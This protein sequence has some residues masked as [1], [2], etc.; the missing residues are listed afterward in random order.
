MNDFEPGFYFT[1]GK[2]KYADTPLWDKEI[3]EVLS[4]IN[5]THR[6]VVDLGRPERYE[7]VAEFAIF[8]EE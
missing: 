1:R 7:I 8:L 5:K 3:P 4:Q 6:L 2:G